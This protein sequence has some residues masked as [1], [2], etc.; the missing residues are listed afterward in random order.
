MSCRPAWYKKLKQQIFQ[1]N[2]NMFRTNLESRHKMT[3]L[4]CCQIFDQR[5]AAPSSGNFRQRPSPPQACE[6]R[7]RQLEKQSPSQLSDLFMYFSIKKNI[8]IM[9]VF[10]FI[11]LNSINFKAVQTAVFYQKN[12]YKK[13][14][15]IFLMFS[16]LGVSCDQNKS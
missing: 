2:S 1:N 13:F 6:L 16:D 11:I 9:F 15:P 10:F 12:M 5:Y 8:F 4:M 7:L 3:V 14:R